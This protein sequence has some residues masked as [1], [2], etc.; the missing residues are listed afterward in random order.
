MTHEGLQV[1]GVTVVMGVTMVMGAPTADRAR[2]RVNMS[3][4]GFY[5][6]VISNMIFNFH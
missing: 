5:F 2:A 1:M 3:T 6:N 4:K